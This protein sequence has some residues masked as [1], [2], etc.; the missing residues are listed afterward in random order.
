[1]LL[2]VLLSCLLFAKPQETS[3]NMLQV[4]E[5]ISKHYYKNLPDSIKHLPWS[6]YQKHLD[7]YTRILDYKEAEEF[8]KS[9]AN[10][11]E[12]VVGISVDS[13]ERGFYIDEVF[14]DGSAYNDGIVRGDI[15][16]K[17]N[18]KKP[19]SH[20]DV[21]YLMRGRIGTKVKLEI[22]RG[23]KILEFNLQRI[24][25]EEPSVF[26]QKKDKTAILQITGFTDNVD[27]EFYIHSVALN[28]KTID[29][30][31]IDLQ[32][33][34][35]GL[36]YKCLRISEEFFIKDEL[37]VTRISK[38][39]TAFDFS[40]KDKG[41]WSD[42]KTIIV[43][44]NHYTASASE[45]LSAVLKYG[46]NAIIIGDTSYGKGL[47]QSQFDVKGGRVFVTSQEYYPL[48][49]VKVNGI[50]VIPDKNLEFPLYD[51][52]TPDFDI[53]KFREEYPLPSLNAL[54]DTR[55]KNKPNISHIIWERDG[56]LF[57]FLLQKPYN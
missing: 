12:G 43:L 52:F 42:V 11:M 31:I 22:S 29:T 5:V 49:K 48:G 24:V 47:V 46:K 15:I 37:M 18:G 35:G 10:R 13:S 53:K 39:D 54:G 44:Q 27:F 45:L 26:S 56:E 40:Q 41:I 51:D 2:Q 55:L 7:R 3:I 6:E 33:N 57:E 50:G 32:Y 4:K 23:K 28:P 20:S 25:L 34:G 9:M 14:K 16:E 19:K 17:I 38:T 36:L 30:L 21:S 8:D 1:M